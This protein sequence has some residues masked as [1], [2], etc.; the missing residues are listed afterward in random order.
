MFGSSLAVADVDDDGFDDVIVGARQVISGTQTGEVYVFFGGA[1]PVSKNA[2]TAGLT[3]TGPSADG[4]FG[5]RVAAGDVTGDDIADI[6]ASNGADPFGA[7]GAGDVYVFEGKTTIVGGAADTIALRKYSGATGTDRLGASI[8]LAQ[9]SN[10]HDRLS[11]LAMGPGHL[12]GAGGLWLL[13]AAD[14]T[15]PASG[16]V[17]GT[18]NVV[19][20]T[21]GDDFRLVL[22][23]VQKPTGATVFVAAPLFGTDEQGRVYGFETLPTGGVT[24]SS[25]A[26]V[27]VTGAT[28][29]RIGGIVV[30]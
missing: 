14:G 12:S 27:Q 25:A 7:V 19:G 30:E 8:R 1:S 24:A 15:L 18:A 29:Q 21:A 11:I 17:D 26:D 10:A 22:D 6:V 4:G 28:N 5:Y 9:M 16:T 20:Q 3:F 2:S 13:S 23:P